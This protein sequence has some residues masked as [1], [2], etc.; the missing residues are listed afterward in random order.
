MIEQVSKATS[1]EPAYDHAVRANQPV[2][3]RLTKY[4]TRLFFSHSTNRG[5]R[6]R[7][8]ENARVSCG[9]IYGRLSFKHKRVSAV[10]VLGVGSLRQVEVGG[11]EKVRGRGNTTA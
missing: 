11:K 4:P 8:K 7:K 9:G 2:D 3:E 10:R 1:A 6:E 5:K